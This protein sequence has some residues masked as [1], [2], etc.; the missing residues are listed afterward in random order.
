MRKLSHVIIACLFGYFTGIESHGQVLPDDFPTFTTNKT[1]E[2]GDGYLFLSVSTD[3]EGI[4]FY[5]MMIDDEGQTFKYKK[6]DRD[7]YSYDFKVQPNGLVS[8]AQFLSHHTY[9]GGGNCIH[10]VLDEEMNPVDSFQLQNGYIAEA[11][12][13]QLLPNGHV[14]AFGYYLTEM[15]L[16][17]VVIGGYPNALVSG[18]IVQELDQET[19]L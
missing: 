12:D 7:D 15:D 6:L 8:Y 2:T 11:H 5:A 10:M 13:F 19:G 18:G 16:S 17:D 3:V 9:T 4:G 1:G 14:L